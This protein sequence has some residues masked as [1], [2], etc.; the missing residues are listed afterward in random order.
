MALK[1]V[2]MYNVH[3]TLNQLY[4][5]WNTSETYN[6]IYLCALQ[7]FRDVHI[8]SIFAPQR[9]SETNTSGLFLHTMYSWQS[10]RVLWRISKENQK[11]QRLFFSLLWTTCVPPERMKVSI[12]KLKDYIFSDIHGKSKKDGAKEEGRLP[13]INIKVGDSHPMI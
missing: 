2:S 8:K 10:C 4:V 7:C 5:L 3:R 12:L 13:K 1:L 6:L 11:F 9:T